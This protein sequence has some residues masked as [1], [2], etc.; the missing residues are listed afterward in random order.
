MRPSWIS[1]SITPMI[2]RASGRRVDLATLHCTICGASDQDMPE[3]GV[4]QEFYQEHANHRSRSGT[5]LGDLVRKVTDFFGAEHCEPCEE[6][7]HA[8]NEIAPKVWWR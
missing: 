5:G 1:L 3:T 2:D 8:L 4:I 6:R 7:Q